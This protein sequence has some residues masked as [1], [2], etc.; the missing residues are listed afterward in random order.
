MKLGVISD[1]HGHLVE[2]RRVAYD[3]E[4][5]LA[6]V[7]GCGQPVAGY[8]ASF[9]LGERIQY[10]SVRPGAPVPAQQA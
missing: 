10:P 1:V 4:A 7:E 8:I 3:R 6:R 5:F 2:H 9:Q